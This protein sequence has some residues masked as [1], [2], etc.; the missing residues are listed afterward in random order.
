MKCLLGHVI[1]PARWTKKCQ[2]IS[3]SSSQPH[4]TLPSKITPSILK[5]LKAPT[6]H[7]HLKMA[8]NALG[9]D[10]PGRTDIDYSA[11]KT[12]PDRELTTFEREALDHM[13]H[14]DDALVINIYSLVRLSEAA[15]AD[16][17]R[18]VAEP[19]YVEPTGMKFKV[20]N[21]KGK[22]RDGDDLDMLRIAKRKR[23]GLLLF[24]DRESLVQR[25]V[26]MSNY[27]V[28]DD[29]WGE[30]G[31]AQDGTKGEGLKVCSLSLWGFG[32]WVFLE[33]VLWLLSPSGDAI[34]SF[35]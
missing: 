24:L 23:T 21:W 32:K 13:P 31:I 33:L 16:I 7:S 2:A 1:E 11:L 30:E 14:A 19:D 4:P 3:S 10:Q 20:V 25:D 6:H 12:G 28:W 27:S 15:I 35:P 17:T 5:H 9:K 29:G 22:D 18:A 34:F 8:Y 26:R